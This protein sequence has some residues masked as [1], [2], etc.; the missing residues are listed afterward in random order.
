MKVWYWVWKAQ[1]GWLLWNFS[2]KFSFHDNLC[3]AGLLEP[4]MWPWELH[5]GWDENC[6]NLSSAQAYLLWGG[7]S[8]AGVL[9]SEEVQPSTVANRALGALVFI[10]NRSQAYLWNYTS[11]KLHSTWKYQRTEEYLVKETCYSKLPTQLVASWFGCL[12]SA[13]DIGVWRQVYL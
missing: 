10:H 6:W 1:Q 13:S 5:K 8:W 11:A 9:V 3:R 7:R 2:S 4:E 12:F